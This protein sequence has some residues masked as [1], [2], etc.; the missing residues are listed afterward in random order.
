MTIAEI[1][2]KIKERRKELKIDQ[3]T[4]AA[5]AGVGINTLVS[6]ERGEGNSKILTIISILDTLGLQFDIIL[7]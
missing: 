5:L 2:I 7:K 3:A 6:V 4:L 1:G